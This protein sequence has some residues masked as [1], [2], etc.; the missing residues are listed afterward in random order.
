VRS[1]SSTSFS[2][3]GTKVPGNE[4]SWERKFLGTW[5]PGNESTRERKSF[6]GAKVR[7]ISWRPTVDTR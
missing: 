3:G 4:S 7:G 1:G 2:L 5:V 6:P